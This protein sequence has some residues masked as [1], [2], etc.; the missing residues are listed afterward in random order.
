MI[1]RLPFLA[2][3]LAVLSYAT[4]GAAPVLSHI[5]TIATCLVA[6]RCFHLL[7]YARAIAEMERRSS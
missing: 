6:A 3:A 7:G 2:L 4:S 1:T 5:L